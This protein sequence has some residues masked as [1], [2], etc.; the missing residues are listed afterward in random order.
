[1]AHAGKEPGIPQHEGCIQGW[2]KA[3]V[4]T[5]KARKQAVQNN[6]FIFAFFLAF[7]PFIL[8]SQE[9]ALSRGIK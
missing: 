1:M 3:A 7:T 6:L 5:C 9:E 4:N 8:G 2:I